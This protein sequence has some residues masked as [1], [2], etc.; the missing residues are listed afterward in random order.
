MRYYDVSVHVRVSVTLRNLSIT[1]RD[2]NRNRLSVLLVNFISISL[3]T[4]PDGPPRKVIV[5]ALNSTTISVKWN[6]PS[7]DRQHGELRGYQVH[8]QVVTV[9]EDPL[10]PVQV[11]WVATAESRVRVYFSSSFHSFHF[12][13]L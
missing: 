4:V 8:Y 7:L 1:L 10:G 3:I 6:P 12:F 9:D 11:E 13:I 2:R 5:E